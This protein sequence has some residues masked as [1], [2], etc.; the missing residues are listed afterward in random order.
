MKPFSRWLGTA[1][2]P[3]TGNDEHRPRPGPARRGTGLAGAQRASSGLR[4][5][6]PCWDKGQA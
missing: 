2:K 3:R 1:T 4:S 6:S 5:Q